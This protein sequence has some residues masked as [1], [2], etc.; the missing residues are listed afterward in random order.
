MT[1]PSRS[2]SLDVCGG[3]LQYHSLYLPQ[4][5]PIYEPEVSALL[6]VL[7]PRVRCF[8]DVGANWGHHTLFLLA[9]SSF[10]GQVESFEPNREI[11]SELCRHL[12]VT[13]NIGR[14]R[15]HNYGLYSRNDSAD[16]YIPD[17][18]HSGLARVIRVGTGKS[19]LLRRG[20]D[21]GLPEP[22]LMKI[23]AEGSEAEVL[24]GCRNIIAR[25]HPVILIELW[26]KRDNITTRVLDFLA[27]LKYQVLY[28][29]FTR[30]C[31]DSVRRGTQG[32]LDLRPLKESLANRKLNAV[33][34][35]TEHWLIE[36]A[37][38]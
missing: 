24:D 3:N 13:G 12:L 10:T 25:R 22:D 20:D 38:A 37:R 34:V 32:R 36:K 5:C 9:Q 19:I 11:A 31:S 4:H 29:V 1:L 26:P 8:W 27:E 28:P 18:L 6:T 7:S 16:L 2:I 23:D 35:S 17:F 30:D 21:T 33:A 15:C 14:A